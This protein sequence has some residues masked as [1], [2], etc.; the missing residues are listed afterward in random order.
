MSKFMNQEER[1]QQ[2]RD[3]MISIRRNT[4]GSNCITIFE[5]LLNEISDKDVV[6]TV[7][8]DMHRFITE[9]SR[10]C[11]DVDNMRNL[12][13][14]A[15][16]LTHDFIQPYRCFH[17]SRKIAGLYLWMSDIL[18]EK[19]KN[20]YV[21]IETKISLP[22]VNALGDIYHKENY[23]AKDLLKVSKYFGDLSKLSFDE[24][25]EKLELARQV[26]LLYN[27]LPAIVKALIQTKRRGLNL[28]KNS[29]QFE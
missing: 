22:N 14:I 20:P 26:V 29:K 7:I 19:I 8:V 25:K 12:D 17:N 28:D 3:L 15:K 23:D 24:A 4:Q 18:K 16:I 9:F 6:D 13:F 5:R 11:K 2:I 21:E 27:Y 1:D 10:L